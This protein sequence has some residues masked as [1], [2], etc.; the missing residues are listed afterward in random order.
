METV[1]WYNF[2][3]GA[4]SI[5]GLKFPE[6]EERLDELSYGSMHLSENM[7]SV[8]LAFFVTT[9]G[10]FL[11]VLG[12]F[13]QSFLPA[14]LKKAWNWLKKVLLWNFCIRLI[15]E[16]SI[17]SI[18]CTNLSLN[19]GSYFC[20]PWGA[21]VNHAYAHFFL[22]VF[23]LFPFFVIFHYCRNFKKLE[24]PAFKGLWGD[25]YQGLDTKRR[26]TL[27]YPVIFIAKR[28]AFTYIVFGLSHYPVAQIMTML[29]VSTAI[30]C[31][32]VHVRPFAEPLITNLEIFNEVM[33]VF[34]VIEMTLFTKAHS[35]ASIKRYARD[36]F[37]AFMAIIIVV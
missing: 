11:I 18:I 32:L 15:M 21:K 16:A 9:I 24:D 1:T 8:F 19:F 6:L 13:M 5:E 28:I 12:S 34:I 33:T 2:P 7:G 4:D 30:S 26:S 22:I 27:Y 31:Y 17:E 29:Y 14:A 23:A 36:G 3:L 35:D 20:V 10:I 37:Y 25:L